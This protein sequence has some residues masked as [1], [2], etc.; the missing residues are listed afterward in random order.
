MSLRKKTVPPKD[1]QIANHTIFTGD[2]L[3]IMRGMNSASIDLIYLDPPFNSNRHYSAPIGSKAAGAEFKDAWTFE[4]TK[5]A[6]WG[7]IADH[8]PALFKVIDAAGDIGNTGDKAY[9]IYMAMR[10]IEIHRILKPTGSLYLHCDPTM[11]HSL[12]MAMDA[13]FG[14]ANF[15][16]EVIWHYQTGGASRNHYS[17]KHDVI[18]FYRASRTY[19]FNAKD[20]RVPRTDEVLRRLASGSDAATRATDATKLAM[21]VWADIQA[22]NAMATERVGYPTQKPLDLLRR[23]IAASSN[24]GDIVLDPF[25]GCATA[26]LA[27]EDLGRQWIGIDIAPLAAKL[28]VQRM[29]DELNLFG[30]IIHRQDIPIRTEDL[31]PPSENITHIL[32]GLQEGKCNGCGISFP[33]QNF[34]R[35]HIIPRSKGGP[36]TDK[37]LQ[38]LC[39]RCNSIKGNRD[40]PYLKARLI[41]DRIIDRP[42]RDDG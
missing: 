8:H 38:L 37:N 35:D 12:K 25:C 15:I 24:E 13:I 40:M 10:L 11:S 41:E 42:R 18:L 28:V 33:F 36:D 32:F 22:L 17:K 27:A 6:W 23:I 19:T 5:D 14:H 3:D 16:N 26:P 34:T 2:N 21:D 7:L 9:L 4:D 1:Q 39:G 20:V 30:D 31:K 29:R